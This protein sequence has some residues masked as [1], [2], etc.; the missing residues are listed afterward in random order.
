MLLLF[1]IILFVVFLCSCLLCTTSV[2][3]KEIIAKDPKIGMSYVP[4]VMII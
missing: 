2:A 1:S 4:V 3:N